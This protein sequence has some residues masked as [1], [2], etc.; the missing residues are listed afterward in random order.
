MPAY[1]QEN[2]TDLVQGHRVHRD[3]YTSP[4]VYRL[5]TQ[6]LFRNVWMFV[7][8]D[9]QTPNKGDYFTT[10]IADQP[11]IQVRHSDGEIHVL[12]NRCPHKGTKI[13]IDR[14][15]NT[16]KFFRCP[17]HA[18]SFKTDGCL[19]AIPLKK[20]YDGT[21][22]KETEN[23]KGMKAV[24]AVHNYRGFVFA[25]L[26]DEGISFEEFFGDSLSSI[27]NM[28]DRAP[29]G[30]MEVA[31]P[32]LRYMHKCNWKMLVENQTDTCHPMVAH[33]SSAGTA[34]KIWDELGNPEPRPAAM[35]IIAPFMSAYDFFEGMGIRTWPNGHGHTGVQGSIHSDYDSI[36]GYF[37]AMTEAYGAD[38]ARA[39][40]DENRHNTVYFPNIMVKAPLGQLRNFIPMGADK[41]L[42]ESYVYRPV[43]A[44]DAL[45]ARSA[46]YNRMINAP[47]S[48]VGHDDLE[49]YERAQEGLMSEGLEWVN[50]QR[51]YQEDEDFDVEAVENGTTERQMRNQ[52]NA[53]AK[54]MTPQPSVPNA[55]AA[56]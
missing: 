26:A 47:T 1:T 38:M 2:V 20:G 19:L 33:E 51:L 31:G 8:H 18:W 28:V 32:P 44:P 16:G 9:S 56:E 55:E 10:Q 29:E 40:L 48:I 43:G 22:L 15:G 34:V 27:D 21:T 23:G 5:E 45:V 11:I 36:P 42:V 13:A 3:L 35:Q 14:E 52:F 39:I 4:E 46:M 53:W 49:M 30:R 17:Y 41:T 37:D 50:V 24:G 12:Y 25:R 7:G 54:F 6:H